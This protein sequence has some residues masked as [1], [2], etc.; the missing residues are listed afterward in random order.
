MID[1]PPLS[2]FVYIPVMVILGMVLGFV[3]GRRSVQGDQGAAG[4]SRRLYDDDLDDY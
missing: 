4:G 2:H 1:I 3:L